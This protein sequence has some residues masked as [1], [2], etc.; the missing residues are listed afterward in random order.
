MLDMHL[1]WCLRYPALI[2]LAHMTEI[3]I[4]KSDVSSNFDKFIT[5][6]K[7]NAL[8]NT[9]CLHVPKYVMIRRKI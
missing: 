6:F 2:H 8:V 7:I 1:H 3:N 5:M 9:G 4:P